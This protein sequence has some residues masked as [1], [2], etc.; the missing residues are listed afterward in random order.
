LIMVCIFCI[1][2]PALIIFGSHLAV[3]FEIRRV[4]N[5][6]CGSTTIKQT[7][8]AEIQFFRV[9]ARTP[10][11]RHGWGFIFSPSFFTFQWW[12]PSDPFSSVSGLVRR[13]FRLLVRLVPVRLFGSV[14]DIRRRIRHPLLDDAHPGADGQIVH[15]LQPHHLRVS[16]QELQVTR[17]VFQPPFLLG[18]FGF[19]LSLLNRYCSA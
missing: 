16:N 6:A 5:A 10:V 3:F 11:S 13:V 9:S 2:M 14:L 15:R 7:I 1:F 12:R 17:N 19:F 8:K 18:F 4:R